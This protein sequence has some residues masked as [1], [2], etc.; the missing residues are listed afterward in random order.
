MI[1]ELKCGIREAKHTALEA[2]QKIVEL[3][4]EHV[5]AGI[6]ASSEEQI[7]RIAANYIMSSW[8]DNPLRQRTPIVR[9]KGTIEDLECTQRMLADMAEAAARGQEISMDRFLS[10]SLGSELASTTSDAEAR[11]YL[12]RCK[13]D[14]LYILS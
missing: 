9:K 3:A 4:T 12:Q 13:S 8:T 5:G 2:S 7:G 10:S 1:Y 6:P 14:V 11:G